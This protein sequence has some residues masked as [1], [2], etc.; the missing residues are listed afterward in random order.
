MKR[1]LTLIFIGL[2]SSPADSQII[3]QFN[4]DNNP[5]TAA[6][7]GPDG[8]V[9]S[10][11][12]IS[13][14]GGVGGTNGLNGALPKQ[15]INMT[16]PGS[17]TF[18]VDGIDVSFDYQREESQCD[19]FRRGNSL[20][21]D[22]SN[23]FAVSYRVED[24]GGGFN[25]VT[26]GNVYNIPN[27]DTWRNYRFIYLPDTGEGFLLLDGLVL[28]TN[29]GP[30]NRPM[31]WLGAGDVTIGFG[32]DGSGSNDTFMDNLIIGSVT[33]SPLPI[34]LLSFSGTPKISSVKLNWTTA[35]EVDNDYFTI[36]R[37]TQGKNWEILGTVDG[38]GNSSTKIDYK[39]SDEAPLIGNSYYRLKQTDFNGEYEYSKIEHVIYEGDPN[40]Q[41]Q[42]YPNPSTGELNVIFQKKDET[43]RIINLLGQ[44]VSNNVR[45]LEESP[46]SVKLNID[47][48]GSGIYFM[49]T[50]SGPIKFRK[51]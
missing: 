6:D 35:S 3:S 30:D 44:D 22:G 46:F 10:S 40:T 38:A 28:W 16:I 37:S 51:K 18:D 25:T 29:D 45:I 49:V 26:S 12:A 7:V 43:W 48:L 2:I 42:L 23:Q 41:V 4:W 17:P 14:I 31:Y 8:T 24:G 47:V 27:D 11:S 33:F 36:E 34:E 20:I 21:M 13:D 32:C 50:D 5:V 1:F 39:Y 19:W 15:D 9:V